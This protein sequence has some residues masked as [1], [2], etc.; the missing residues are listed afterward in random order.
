MGPGAST[1]GWTRRERP[2]ADARAA[3]SGRA[4]GTGLAEPLAQAPQQL[5][6]G[7]HAGR[8]ACG[9]E[10]RLETSAHCAPREKS[11]CEGKNFHRDGME[12]PSHRA[13]TT[14]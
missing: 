8:E 14:S 7:P 4:R 11:L 2:S 13:T 1:S 9:R 6:S 10:Q 12:F 3:H 5:R